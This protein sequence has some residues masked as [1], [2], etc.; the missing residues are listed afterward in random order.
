V[1]TYKEKI[2]YLNNLDVYRRTPYSEALRYQHKVLGTPDE[3][4]IVGGGTKVSANHASMKK[5]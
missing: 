5:K 3:A 1:W 2:D 4:E